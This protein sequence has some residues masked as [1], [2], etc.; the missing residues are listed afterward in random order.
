MPASAT[1]EPD[2]GSPVGTTQSPSAPLERPPVGP[3]VRAEKS[4]IADPPAR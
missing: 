2:R 3:Q 1:S 4:A